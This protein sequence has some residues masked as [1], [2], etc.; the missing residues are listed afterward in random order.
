MDLAQTATALRWLEAF[1]IFGAIF[2]ALASVY[3][4]LLI[5]RYLG[6]RA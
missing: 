4:F 3:I 2:F 5:G 6:G 1:V